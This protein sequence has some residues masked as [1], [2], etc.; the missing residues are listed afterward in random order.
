M[1][2]PNFDAFAEEGLVFDH[3]YCNMA[4]CSASRNSFMTGRNR[5]PPPPQAH[6][7]P[8]TRPRLPVLTLLA[9]D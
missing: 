1:I 2:T 9:L 6:V 8:P 7:T 5:A 4:I 3:A